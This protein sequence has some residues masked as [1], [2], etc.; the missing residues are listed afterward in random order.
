MAVTANGEED[1]YYPD[2]PRYLGPATSCTQCKEKFPKNSVVMVEGKQNGVQI[3]T[4]K[5]VFCATTMCCVLWGW[6]SG[7]EFD[8]TQAQFRPSCI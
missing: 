1:V 5:E 8:V 3:I 6:G 7:R 2:L 4:N